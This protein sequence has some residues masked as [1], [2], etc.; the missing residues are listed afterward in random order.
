MDDADVQA[1]EQS[2]GTG[3]VLSRIFTVETGYN[4]AKTLVSD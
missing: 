1:I 4:Y 2:L 3:T